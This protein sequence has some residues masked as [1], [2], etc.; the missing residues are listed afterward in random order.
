M[1]KVDTQSSYGVDGYGRAA[2]MKLY[3]DLSI[4]KNAL[5]GA[6]VWSGMSLN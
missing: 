1:P 5:G 2:R 4:G 6:G 3:T